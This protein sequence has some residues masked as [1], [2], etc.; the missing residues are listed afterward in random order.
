MGWFKR[1]IKSVASTAVLLLLLLLG[2]ACAVRLWWGPGHR[3]II[4][5]VREEGRLTRELLVERTARLDARFDA[6]DAR[7][8]DQDA[9]LDALDAK[10]DT[11]LR[12]ARPPLPDG[13]QREE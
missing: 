7:L 5:V 8:S 3:E 2:A 12:L 10:L 4:D 1:R 9:K 6:L 11:L 13:L